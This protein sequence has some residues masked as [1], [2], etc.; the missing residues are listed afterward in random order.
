MH[1]RADLY[2]R[3]IVRSCWPHTSLV[4]APPSHGGP[5]TV[6]RACV[7]NALFHRHTGERESGGNVLR[8]TWA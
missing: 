7:E 5:W 1:D 3:R 8:G 4:A 6:P 2:L